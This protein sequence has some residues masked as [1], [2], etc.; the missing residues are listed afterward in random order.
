MCLWNFDL[1]LYSIIGEIHALYFGF[2]KDF[3]AT[4]S[5]MVEQ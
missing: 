1:N 5:R 2:L 3:R 4:L